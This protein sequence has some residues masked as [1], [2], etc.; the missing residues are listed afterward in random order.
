VLYS[1]PNTYPGGRLL[2]AWLHRAGPR[3]PISTIDLAGKGAWAVITGIGGEGWKNAAL[4]VGKELKVAINGHSIGFRQDW[5]DVY[6]DWEKVRGVEESGCVLVRP[7]RFV[8]WRAADGGKEEA[9]LLKM[10]KLLLGPE[11]P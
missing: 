11:E 8:A 4:T 2:H 10:M 7:D 6:Y 1:V 5:E 3:T 9:R